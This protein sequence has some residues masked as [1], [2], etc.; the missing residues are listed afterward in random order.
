M[1]LSGS[2]LTKYGCLPCPAGWVCLPN[3]TRQ[4]GPDMWSSTGSSVCSNCST[5]DGDSRLVLQCS[6]V[7]DVVCHSC[8]D[9]FVY[10]AGQCTPIHAEECGAYGDVA[11]F[12]LICAVV[13]FLAWLCRWRSPTY[14]SV[15]QC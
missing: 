6:P 8:P 7:A 10:R 15:Q 11:A 1:C 9:A 2:V 4:C 5:C 3:S 12:L 13:L 14:T